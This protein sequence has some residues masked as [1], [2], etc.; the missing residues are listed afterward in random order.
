MIPPPPEYYALPPDPWWFW[1][2]WGLT[3]AVVYGWGFWKLR[4]AWKLAQEGSKKPTP[5]EVCK[6]P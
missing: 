2:A 6:T 1:L 3:Q 5:E 4:K